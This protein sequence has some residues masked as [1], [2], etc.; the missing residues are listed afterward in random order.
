MSGTVSPGFVMDLIAVNP[1]LRLPG[2]VD[3]K[4]LGQVLE[5]MNDQTHRVL[6]LTFVNDEKGLDVL[7]LR[8]D[9]SDHYFF[10][11]PAWVKGNLVRFF[12]GYPGRIFGP[13]YHV[14]DSVRGGLTLSITAVEDAALNKE[15][16]VRH[17]PNSSIEEILVR[18]VA[19]GAF[20]P[21]VESVVTTEDPLLTVKKD[22]TQAR[23][24]NWQFLQR[25]AEPIGYEVMIDD[26]VQLAF[27][28]RDF[29]ALPK[30]KFEYWFG[31]GDLLSYSVKEWRAADRPSRTV[32]CGRDPIERKSMRETGSNENTSRDVTGNQNALARTIEN[33]G[34]GKRVMAGKSVHMTAAD[35]SG[36]VKAEA[37]SRF[38][39]QEQKELEVTFK[40]IGDPLLPVSSL[41]QVDGLSRILSGIYYVKKH[42]HVINR[43]SGYTGTMECLRNAVTAEP[44]SGPSS[45]SDLAKQNTKKAKDGLQGRQQVILFDKAGNPY[46]G[47]E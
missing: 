41:I 19:E 22:R 34:V 28:K 26:G 10:E 8:V 13:R 29:S 15:A 35:N 16:E 37:D 43:T 23:Q 11:H 20:G 46:Q 36:D 30:R 1:E 17:W 47:K 44:T 38:R 7:K 14:I 2:K 31:H 25:L 12:F 45:V 18:L 42:T 5:R 24:S 40:I 21:L 39:K 6:S 27:R 4:T 9:N 33:A 3:D 32:V